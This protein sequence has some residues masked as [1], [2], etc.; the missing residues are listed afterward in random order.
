[1]IR[2]TFRATLDGRVLHGHDSHMQ[3]CLDPWRPAPEQ[4]ITSAGTSVRILPRAL[5]VAELPSGGLNADLGGG[6]FDDVTAVLAAKGV[7]NV[8]FDPF[9]RPRAHNEAAAELL[10]GGRA[11]TATIFNVLN[12]MSCPEAR[13]RV[14]ALAADAIRTG[15]SAWFQVYEGD[16][17]GRGARSTKG[18]QENRPLATYLPEI[19]VHF[20]EVSSRG[21]VVRA[22][23]ARTYPWRAVGGHFATL[24]QA[25]TAA[26]GGA[27]AWSDGSPRRLRA[28]PRSM[29]PRGRTSA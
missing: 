22:A 23:G 19:L 18:W 2:E 10:R 7:R 20:A 27:V 1:M 28:M 5:H 11:D 9:N 24:E 12:V 15:G 29:R 26:D 4:E 3:P 25:R 21:G 14:V 6:R 16:R 13:D 8:I 17:S